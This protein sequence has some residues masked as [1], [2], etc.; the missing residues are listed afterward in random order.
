MPI[1]EFIC[2]HCGKRNEFITF[3]V[4][5]PVPDTCAHCEQTGL[6]RIPSRVRVRLSEETRLERLAD[7]SRFGS[8][9]ENDPKSMARF[10][11]AM[12]HE[13]GDDLDE[14]VDSLIEEAMEEEAAGGGEGSSGAGDDG[15]EDLD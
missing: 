12:T 6:R 2:T 14:D 13:M 3:R 7:P 8:L 10:M 9:D 1:Y 5:E 4:S 11:K 15:T